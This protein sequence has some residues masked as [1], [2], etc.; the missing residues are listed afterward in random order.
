M[1]DWREF[2]RGLGTTGEYLL[3][4]HVPG[5]RHRCYAP[6]LF[7]RTVH[8]CAR[9]TGVYPG[10][11]LGLGWALLG[12]AVLPRLLLVAVLPVVALFDWT[13]TAYTDRRGHNVVRTATGALLG[14]AYGLGLVLLF[15]AGEV[16]VLAVGA[17]YAVLAGALLRAA[18]R[19]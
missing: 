14:F 11:L 18:G 12:P 15:L 17:V 3:S 1:T 6:R 13:V 10:I 16:L 8:L 19:I 5:E 4:H 7:G 2:R 9:C